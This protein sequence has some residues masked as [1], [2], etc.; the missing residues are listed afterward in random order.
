MPTE[1]PTADVLAIHH[2]V[3]QY[4]HVVDSG[5]VERLAEVFTADA[6]FDASAFGQGVHEGL[7]AIRA[8]FALGAPPHPPAH[9]T[10]NVVVD[11]DRD[12]DGDG[13]TA[14]SKWLTIDRETAGV[15]SGD[16]RDRVVA[17]DAGWRIAHRAI[18]IR[19]YVGTVPEAPRG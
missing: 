9:L 5:D 17:T 8:I 13:W 14:H 7:A 3:A 15:R 16:Y 12:G 6:I 18:T 1:Q 2:L 10:T 4:G 19:F 11:R